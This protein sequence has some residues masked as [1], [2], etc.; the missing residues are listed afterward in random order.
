M[1]R[2]LR[3][4]RDVI[5]ERF[6]ESRLKPL[7]ATNLAKLKK[8]FPDIPAHI[9]KFFE[10]VGCGCI[11]QSRYM[12]YDLHSPQGIFDKETAAYLEGVV[13]IGDDFAGTH[14]AYDTRSK[15][16]FGSVGAGGRFQPHSRYANFVDF[17]EAWYVNR[18]EA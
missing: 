15:W 5:L 6:P 8:T 2:K 13:L 4:I 1:I 16:R 18:V 17:I 9:V 7:T 3:K 14:E 12:I 10:T 11:G